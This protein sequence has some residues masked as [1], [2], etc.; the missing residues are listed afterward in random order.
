[1][2]NKLALRNAGRLWKDYSNYY[3][4]LCMIAALTF[5]FHSLLF[6]KD[7]YAIIH[8]GNNGE[9]STGGSM[10][11][12]FMSVS[13]VAILIITGW[14]M[15]YM[16]RFMLE[17]R[18][19]E[20]A[21]YLLAGMKKK[22]IADL[23]MKENLYLG[24]GALFAGVLLGCGLRRA[25]FFAFYKSIGKNLKFARQ[26]TRAEL[27]TFC[28]T[29]ILYGACFVIAQ[30]RSRNEFSHMQIINLITMEKRNETVNERQNT[31]WKNLFFLSVGNI[32]LFYFLIFTGRI[33]RWTAILEMIGLLFTFYFFYGGL[34]AFLMKY[35]R[36]KGKLI[37][38]KENLFLI[39]QFSSK[40]RNT[41]F[42]LGTLSLLFMFA[43]VGSSLALMLSDYQNRQLN[44]EYPFDI[45]MIS[46]NTDNDFSKEEAL[47]VDSMTPRH[48]LKY[49]VYQNGTC[50]MGDFLYQNLKLFSGKDSDPVM[51]EGKRAVAYYDYD[52][53][54]GVGDYNHLRE[55]LGLTRVTLQDNQYLIHMP[56]RVYQEIKDK[57]TQLR[58]SLHTGLEFAGFQTDGF[59]QNGHNG[60]DYLLVV[61]DKKLTEMK[62]YFSLM[63]VTADGNVP[64][65]LSERLYELAGKTRGYDELADY[66]K[67]GSEQLFLMPA[68]IQVKSREI[69]ELKFLMSTLSFPLFYIGLV[70]LC[71]S[72][73][74]LSVQQL[75]DSHKYK[76]RYQ[77]LNKLGMGNKRIRITVAKQLFFYYL[78]PVILSVIISAVFIIYAG[79]QFVA[80]TGIRTRGAF[81]FCISLFVFL[82]IYVI[83][84]VLTYLQFEKNIESA[85]ERFY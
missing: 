38:K 71:A 22:Q 59:A 35:I 82:G 83:Y 8:Y 81:Y 57:G 7:I 75:S 18:S 52:V 54:M 10:L 76:I 40:L 43:L 14:L 33:T 11:I 66:I 69:L 51:A 2:L 47:I 44:V 61:P 79:R 70:F 42:V 72:F 41:C 23:F 34:S 9:L 20:F 56:N 46:D 21:I 53:Y 84:F 55:M 48:I 65:N 63:A 73:T 13:T 39:R 85:V 19:R 32:L 36:G 16:T 49:C 77:V 67:I 64:E 60:S 37:Y 5:S 31:T 74:V 1:M 4:T 28:V 17:K 24:V 15:N 58:N 62:K 25:L 27:L 26:S 12:T 68:A 50:E 30:L 3:L 29:V 6:S 78:C 80:Y 45:I